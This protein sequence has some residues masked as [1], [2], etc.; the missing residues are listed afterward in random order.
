MVSNTH[1]DRNGNMFPI[2]KNT[3]EPV[4]NCILLIFS[5]KREVNLQSI[6]LRKINHEVSIFSHLWRLEPLMA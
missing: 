3:V 2:L 5:W 6:F 1:L 4:G